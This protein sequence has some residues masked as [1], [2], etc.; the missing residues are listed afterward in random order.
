MVVKDGMPKHCKFFKLSKYCNPF[1]LLMFE[2]LLINK[3]VSLTIALQVVSIC[4]LALKQVGYLPIKKFL[5]N[6]SGKVTYWALPAVANS[7]IMKGNNIFLIS[8]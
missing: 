7:K 4:L 8:E 6:V 3:S 2:L 5:N 1:K